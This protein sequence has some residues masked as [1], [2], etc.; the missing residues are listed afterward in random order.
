MFFGGARLLSL[1]ELIE[2]AADPLEAQD[3]AASGEPPAL[4]RITTVQGFQHLAVCRNGGVVMVS[5]F[6]SHIKAK[7]WAAF[8]ERIMRTTV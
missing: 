8:L 1:A 3:A 4:L 7:T 5:G 2:V 6:N